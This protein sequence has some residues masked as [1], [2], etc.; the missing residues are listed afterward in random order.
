M[1]GMFLLDF[2]SLYPLR[3]CHTFGVHNLRNNLYSALRLHLFSENPKRKK[4]KGQSI[5][6][7]R[8]GSVVQEPEFFLIEQRET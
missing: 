5:K 3:I 6:K 7:P 2:Y 1:F 4:T 8:K